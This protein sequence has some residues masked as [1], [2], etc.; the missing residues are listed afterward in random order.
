VKFHLAQPTGQNVFTAYGEDYV[1]VNRVRYEKSLV[2][3][4]DRPVE[5][6]PVPTLEALTRE[7]IEFLAGFGAEVV[8]LGTGRRLHF[9]DPALLAPLAAVRVGVEVMDTQAA[10]RTYNILMAEGRK[11]IAALIL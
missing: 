2:V 7:R 8:L 6:W 4:P 11:V 5:D 3:A 9:P 1:M 10:C